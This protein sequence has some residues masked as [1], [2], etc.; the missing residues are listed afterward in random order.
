MDVGVS[1]FNIHEGRSYDS[2][3]NL[4]EGESTEKTLQSGSTIIIPPAQV[5]FIYYSL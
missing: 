4:F 5:G 3:L 1:N 2:Y